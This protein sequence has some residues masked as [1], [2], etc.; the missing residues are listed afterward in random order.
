MAKIDRQLTILPVKIRQGILGEL[1]SLRDLQSAILAC[2]GL[3][4]A[5]YTSR[6]LIR[7]TVFHKEYRSPASAA[8]NGL[9]LAS[10]SRRVKRLSSN[11]PSDGRIPREALWPTLLVDGELNS[12]VE[13]YSW[14]SDLAEAYRAAG[15][16]DQAPAVEEKTVFLTHCHGKAL[17]QRHGTFC[18]QMDLD[19]HMDGA[20]C[21]LCL[22]AAKALAG[23][24]KGETELEL[25]GLERVWRE[26]PPRS[27]AFGPWS[28]LFVDGHSTRLDGVLKIWERLREVP[29]A[30]QLE[31]YDLDWAREVIQ[32]L[33]KQKQGSKG[34]KQALTFQASVFALL[35]A[36]MHQYYAFGRNL[37]D[38]YAKR[39][40]VEEAVNVREQMMRNTESSAGIYKSSGLALAHLYGKLG[41]HELSAQV[42][43]VAS[44]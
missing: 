15:L 1:I 28:W 7:Q 32:E 30:G 41:R 23:A 16:E 19:R 8:A 40:D 37:A 39:G 6:S 22:D 11:S 10:A 21:I 14:S 4:A 17:W 9:V 44:T 27:N 43:S 24:L 25:S 12:T 38:A 35:D 42:L 36:R 18:G 13:F 29:D 20:F 34:A 5:Y 2:R 3:A 33:R 31:T 26:I